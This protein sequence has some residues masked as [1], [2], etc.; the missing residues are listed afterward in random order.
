MQDQETTAPIPAAPQA[1]DQAPKQAS[2]EEAKRDQFSKIMELAGEQGLPKKAREGEEPEAAAGP[3]PEKAR[4]KDGKFQSKK[5]EG[6][7]D[8][9]EPD[10]KSR[11]TAL[12]SDTDYES[13]LHTLRRAHYTTTE[14]DA[15]GDRETVI[16]RAGPIAKMLADSERAYTRAR[17]AEKA[18]E[19]SAASKSEEGSDAAQSRP[20][21]SAL[22]WEK[23]ADALGLALGSDEDAK[24]LTGLIRKVGDAQASK[25]AAAEASLAEMQG[26][27]FNLQMES[28]RRDLQGRF[29]EFTD[30]ENWQSVRAKLPSLK[31][32]A[33][34][35][36]EDMVGDA[37]RMMGFGS[38]AEPG[39]RR[40]TSD[41]NKLKDA[42]RTASTTS[43]APASANHEEA[44]RA[45]WDK[46]MAGVKPR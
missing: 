19:Q 21:P 34:Q 14:I 15:M 9:E 5:G 25:V 36:I 45:E 38:Q 7:E 24:L 13:A 37:A 29:P 16:K 2:S 3:E 44:L 30:N 31:A 35:S 40:R 20:E 11:T 39:S 33:Y 12:E 1:A 8:G 43:A 41:L 32:E 17:E 23:E 28:V 10:G 26:I 27:V 42:G 22:D 4:S 18:L 6:S 46:H